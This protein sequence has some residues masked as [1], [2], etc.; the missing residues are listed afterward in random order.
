MGIARGGV[1]VAE[2]VAKNMKLPLE[3]LVVK[4]IPSPQ[5]PEFAIGALA[6]DGVSYINWKTA[7]RVGADED[8]INHLLPILTTSIMKR[9]H[10]YRRKRKPIPLRERTVYVIDDGAATGATLEVAVKWLKKKHAKKI[11]VAIPVATPHVVAQIRPEVDELVVA[12]IATEFNAVGQFYK[13]FD[14]VSDA[15]VAQLLI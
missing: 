12:D 3:V 1:A 15:R 7:G 4:K 8:Y 2:V 11:I 5:D 6:P 10:E 9:T 13:N 14:E